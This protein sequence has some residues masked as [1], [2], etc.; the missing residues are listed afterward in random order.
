MSRTDESRR[1]EHQRRARAKG[2]LH[3]G[4]AWGSLR[5][6]LD[7]VLLSILFVM[8]IE[9]VGCGKIL[10]KQVTLRLGH[11]PRGTMRPNAWSPT[12]SSL[13]LRSSRRSGWGGVVCST[14]CHLCSNEPSRRQLHRGCRLGH[15]LGI[16]FFHVEVFSGFVSIWGFLSYRRPPVIFHLWT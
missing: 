12:R 15:F 1:V 8:N 10:R 7:C 13:T 4:L 5:F 14:V 9:A 2:F 6:V 3:R 16:L 11:S